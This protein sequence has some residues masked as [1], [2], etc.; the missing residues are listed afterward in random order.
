ML[1][2]A[3][4]VPQHLSTPRFGLRENC[5]VQGLERKREVIYF[6]Y[7]F[8]VYLVTQGMQAKVL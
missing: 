4:D 2:K 8:P 3:V 5:W 7:H 6:V 1:L